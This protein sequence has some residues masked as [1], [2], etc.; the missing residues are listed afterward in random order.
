MFPIPSERTLSPVE[1][2]EYWSREITLPASPQELRDA[3][4]KAWWSGELIATNGASRLDVLRG[5]YSRSANFIA[6][7]IPNIEEPPQWEPDGERV[8]E[9]VRPLRVP[10]PNANLDTWTETNCA[11]AFDA[12]AKQWKEAL[13]SPHAPIF[14]D[15]VLTSSEFFQW[16]DTTGYERPKKFWSCP[17]ADKSGVAGEDQVGFRESDPR[18]EHGAIPGSS[19]T[20]AREC[21]LQEGMRST[22][23]QQTKQ[24]R[25]SHGTIPT[26]EITKVQPETAKSR[27]AWEVLNGLW[28]DG[29]PANLQTADIH[30]KVNRWIEKLPRAKYPFTQVSRETV[31]RLLG[32]KF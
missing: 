4:S 10:L 5:C 29:P 15:F 1:I 19:Q 16:I 27:A 14:L 26:I 22:T 18:P 17:L 3:I 9:Y 24:G 6:F 31:A 13:I 21:A 28:P 20:T 12:I 30:R 8:I 25:A 11:P 7:A 23:E 32:R 2:A